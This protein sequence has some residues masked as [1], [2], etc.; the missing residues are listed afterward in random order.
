MTPRGRLE[1]PWYKCHN[2]FERWFEYADTLAYVY[3]A[4]TGQTQLPTS[5][6]EKR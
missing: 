1:M 3:A 6:E 5:V 2:C 4:S